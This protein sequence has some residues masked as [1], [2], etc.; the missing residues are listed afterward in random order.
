MNKKGYTLPE[1]LAVIAIIGI[2]A[3]V[4]TMAVTKYL[5]NTKNTAYNTLAKS[6]VEATDNY[7]LDNKANEDGKYSLKELVDG[8]YLENRI[9]PGKKGSV[10]DGVVEYTEDQST[11]YLICGDRKLKYTYKNDKVEKSNSIS[12]SEIAAIQNYLGLPTDTNTNTNTNNNKP[13]IYEQVI[14]TN[15][16]YEFK[17]SVNNLYYSTDFSFDKNTGKYTLSNSGLKKMLYTELNKS[18]KNGNKFYTLVSTSKTQ[19]K[20]TMYYIKKVS[21][22][23]NDSYTVDIYTS[24]IIK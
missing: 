5:T 6:S 22:K 2:L 19:K 15:K 14:Q 10:C 4:A 9:D 17:T 23:E 1:L 16:N 13:K 11:I 3:G 8:G 12:D 24:K 7:I 21:T 20:D 18:V